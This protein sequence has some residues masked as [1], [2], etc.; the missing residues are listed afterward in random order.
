MTAGGPGAAAIAPMTGRGVLLAGLYND[1]RRA[2][3]SAFERSAG[4]GAAAGAAAAA[5]SSS[6]SLSAMSMNSMSAILKS[7]KRL[8]SFVGVASLRCVALR[9]VTFLLLFFV[10]SES[11]PSI[12]RYKER[13]YLPTNVS[14]RLCTYGGCMYSQYSEYVQ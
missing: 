14:P 5:L 10:R 4:E 6:L 9:Y 11:S 1:L 2:E 13:D 3:R 8:R 12:I 7:I